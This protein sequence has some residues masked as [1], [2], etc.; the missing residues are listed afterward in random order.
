MVKKD[1]YIIPFIKL[2][3]ISRILSTESP[4]SCI[5]VAV[6]ISHLLELY[7]INITMTLKKRE[8]KKKKK[9]PQQTVV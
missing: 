4:S 7:K 6:Q 5:Y 8:E 3:L 9:T 1:S 2:Q